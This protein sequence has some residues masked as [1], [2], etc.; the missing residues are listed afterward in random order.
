M[1]NK[2]RWHLQTWHARRRRLGSRR[3]QNPNSIDI[4]RIL[5]RFRMCITMSV[6]QGY[7]T[8]K[9]LCTVNTQRTSRQ[10]AI[11]TIRLYLAF[12]VRH[13]R[14]KKLSAQHFSTLIFKFVYWWMERAWLAIHVREVIP[15]CIS[16][17]I[18]DYVPSIH[19]IRQDKIQ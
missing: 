12:L 17:C 11:I 6:Y 7:M 2:T 5:S 13:W 14:L 18:I 15:L 19:N 8:Y 9:I 1:Q 4:R 3:Y 10:D 16:K